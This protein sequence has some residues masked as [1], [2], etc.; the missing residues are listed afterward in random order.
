MEQQHVLD[1]ILE[2]D[3]ELASTGQRFLNNI[4]DT[5]AFYILVTIV[6]GIGGAAL[7]AS[8]T[9]ND[10]ST[11][12]QVNDSLGGVLGIYF[13]FFAVFFLYY[14]LFEGTKGKTLGKFIT[15]T[16]VVCENGEAMSFKKAFVRSLCRLVP[17]EAISI[18]FGAQMWHDKWT[19]TMVVRDN[20]R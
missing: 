4:I 1:E 20:Q 2:L 8:G 10:L 17:F 11:D 5:I 13:F 9:I 15:K 7:F 18:F 16:K 6:F 12:E 3:Y 19:G 14:V